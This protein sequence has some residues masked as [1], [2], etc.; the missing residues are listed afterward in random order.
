MFS[1]SLNKGG[2][3][4]R[5]DSVPKIDMGAVLGGLRGADGGL[6]EIDLEIGSGY[7]TLSH[8]PSQYSD[9]DTFRCMLGERLCAWCVFVRVSACVSVRVSVSVCV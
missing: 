9:E 5:P 4:S 8:A 6:D 2:G 1:P 3:G 7:Q